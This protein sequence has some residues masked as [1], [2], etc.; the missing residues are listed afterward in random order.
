MRRGCKYISRQAQNPG[1]VLE[2]S[3][4]FEFAATNR[5]L[6]R[7]KYR[8]DSS[9]WETHGTQEAGR[10]VPGSLFVSAKPSATISGAA[11]REAGRREYSPQ[12]RTPPSNQTHYPAPGG[13]AQQDLQDMHLSRKP[14][15]NFMCRRLKPYTFQNDMALSKEYT[16]KFPLKGLPRAHTKARV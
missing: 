7:K 14:S 2:M 5:T 9:S 10:E 15:N 6:W 13:L 16:W 11:R 3:M 12:H 8:L 1:R 4:K